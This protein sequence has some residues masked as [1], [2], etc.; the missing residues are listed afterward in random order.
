MKCS[1]CGLNLEDGTLCPVCDGKAKTHYV[2]DD[3]QERASLRR[4]LSVMFWLSIPSVFGSLI[5]RL[6]VPNLALIGSIF[7]IVVDFGFGLALFKLSSIEIRYR[8]ALVSYILSFVAAFVALFM[9]I[10]A[11]AALAAS[12]LTVYFEYKANA[13]LL[14]YH[15]PAIS[16]AWNRLLKWTIAIYGAM[17]AILFLAIFLPTLGLWLY[18]LAL[19]G[20]LIANIEKLVLLSVTSSTFK[21]SS[22]TMAKEIS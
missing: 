14:E 8:K 16:E 10:I 2:L 6:N 22:P 11:L 13:A 17:I 20:L 19:V 1:S 9:P 7:L 18:C 3:E 21:Q 4:W 12:L 5:S 15:N